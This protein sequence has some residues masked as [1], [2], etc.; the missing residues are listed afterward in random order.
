[1][2][3]ANKSNVPQLSKW[4]LALLIGVGTPVAFGIAYWYLKKR[5]NQEGSDLSCEDIY[6]QNN[7]TNTRKPNLFNKSNSVKKD[8]PKVPETPYEKAKA[9]KDK[10]NKLFKEGQFD[11]A[12]E[13]YTSAIEMCPPDHSDDLAT[14]YQNRAAAYENLKNF[15]AVIN[16]TT[17]ALEHNKTYLK[18]LYRRA[19]AY[20]TTAQLHKCLEDVTALC[21]F[22]AFRTEA[23]LK[24]TDK[25]LKDLSKIEA[26]ETFSKRIPRLPSKHFIRH[27]F[28]SFSEDPIMKSVE[29]Y[30][31]QM[32]ERNPS[33]LSGFRL[34]IH[35]FAEEK[36]EEI[37][38]C[39][40]VEIERKGPDMAE[41]LLV[42][43]TFKLLQGQISDSLSD[44]NQLLALE[45]VDVKVRVNC[46]IKV[47]SLKVQQE[48]MEEALEDFNKA[49]QLDPNNA[50]I[51]LHRGQVYVLM[52]RIQEC[53]KDM[54]KSCSLNPNFPSARAQK[55]YIQYRCG[56]QFNDE[57]QKASAF[58]GFD[59]IEKNF[60]LCSESYF[61]YAQVLIECGE[62]EK[63]EKYF[64]KAGELDP[65]DPN[66]FVHQGILALQWKEDVDKALVLFNKAIEMDDKCQFGYETLGSVEVQRG[67][68]KKGLE[69]FEKAVEVAH[70]ETELAHLYSLLL[71]AKAQ[72]K[73]A[74]S[75][76]FNA[77]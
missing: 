64:K 34:V 16:D 10:G 60:P 58:K 29:E 39:C 35:H 33:E 73:T 37:M 46:L 19:K 71:A 74:E 32:K 51:Y 67:N 1:M 20:E 31:K 50:D 7:D 26:K 56:I 40:D 42:R 28:I 69:L 8:N 4:Q 52:E 53:L 47:G 25:V 49:I 66:V 23:Y 13:C 44:L 14:F 65:N 6:E 38:P 63:A 41:A 18:A 54:E 30:K 72:A 22:D 61:L 27:Y 24:L 48:Q 45:S 55:C 2:A 59:E 21:M 17:K 62:Y 57:N 12:I 11:K 68:I 15:E 3:A 75:F 36:F 70:T 5:K 77:G 43:G 9:F 76:G